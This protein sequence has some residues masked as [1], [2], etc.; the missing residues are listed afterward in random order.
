V[1]VPTANMGRVEVQS[2]ILR[3]DAP[4]TQTGGETRLAGGDV[5]ATAPFRIEGGG[6]TG[7]GTVDGSVTVTA[8]TVSPDAAS[9]S[10]KISGD[11]TQEASGTYTSELGPTASVVDR[12]EPLGTAA[13][14]GV[15][16]VSL[17]GGY[18][19]ARGDTFV[20]MTYGARTGQF[21]TVNVPA[22]SNAELRVLYN[23]LDVTLVV[24][25]KGQSGAD[26]E[27]QAPSPPPTKPL[28]ISSAPDNRA[29]GVAANAVVTAQ[30]PET[31]TTSTITA[32][33]FTLVRWTSSPDLSQ[34][35]TQGSKVAVTSTGTYDSSTRTATLRPSAPLVEGSTYTATIKSGSSGVKTLS[36]V[37]LDADKIWSFRTA[38]TADTTPPTA[39]M[40][41]SD[42]TVTGAA[43][44]TLQVNASDLG[45]GVAR[46]EFQVS[47]DGGATW[48]SVASTTTPDLRGTYSVATT[49]PLPPLPSGDPANPY[50]PYLTRAIATDLFGHQTTTAPV[51]LTVDPDSDA[52]GLPD[53]WETSTSGVNIDQVT[54]QE[55]ATVG[56][57]CV[58]VPL[59]ALGA[60]PNRRDVFV[61][62]DAMADSTHTPAFNTTALKNVVDAF[63][64]APAPPCSG[65]ICPPAGITLHIDQGPN[66]VFDWRCDGY[67]AI[68]TCLPIA[69]VTNTSGATIVVTTAVDLDSTVFPLNAQ[70]KI[71][72]AGVAGTASALARAD[73]NIGANG[74]WT[75]TV[76][77]VRTL[78]LTRGIATGSP[79]GTGT[80]SGTYTANSGVL[81]TE[82]AMWGT[83]SAARTVPEKQFLGTSYTDIYGVIRYRWEPPAG[84][85]VPTTITYVETE[86]RVPG[87]IRDKGRVP[88]FHYVVSGHQLTTTLNVTGIARSDGTGKGGDFVV[89]VGSKSQYA[90]NI[91]IQAG[92]LMHELGHNLGLEHGGG[93]T[94]NRKPNYLSVMNYNFQETGLLRRGADGMLT[95]GVMDYSRYGPSEIPEVDEAQVSEAMGLGAAEAT[96]GTRRDCNGSYT[97]V[98]YPATGT[99]YWDWDCD[100]A[101][102]GTTRYA[103]DVNG[104][105]VPAQRYGSYNDW[106]N[107]RFAGGNVGSAG[108][109]IQEPATE[110]E[111][112]VIGPA[113]AT[114]DAPIPPSRSLGATKTAI[115]VELHPND[116]INPGSNAP[117]QVVIFSHQGLD[118][119]TID[120]T[121]VRFG[122][123][124]AEAA[125]VTRDRMQERDTDG[126]GLLDLMVRFDAQEIRLTAGAT[127]AC[128]VGTLSDGTNIQGCASVRITVNR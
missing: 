21:T 72:V 79:A 73:G 123:P 47:S 34:D 8:G 49:Q 43:Q 116:A 64:A 82:A 67:V 1:S 29:Q 124:G 3:F 52:D 76:T 96:Y 62:I 106:A 61:Q 46:V 63:A 35:V 2:G 114:S 75:A 65:Q 10:L 53:R 58:N 111:S 4:Y 17:V 5:V 80:G 19:P 18:V 81:Y 54:G 20:I 16:N 122:P 121:T 51:S 95:S 86:K 50:K 93:D 78:S 99:R 109:V 55:C 125:R 128:L 22:L 84:T 92:T 104:D 27:G 100:A 69:G 108:V 117:L 85:T 105:G 57:T 126:D 48:Q 14:Q 44:P 83:R 77:G 90:I 28:A 91:K 74:L 71:A 36:G 56:G 94:I 66:S 11:Y 37:V 113:S 112:L 68:R 12:L 45:S 60:D 87:G 98:T 6:L 115:R 89:T 107:L 97:E 42:K 40:I 23:P 26:P 38:V 15:L 110:V 33:T 70:V 120:P 59:K 7:H 119:T 31:M 39:T 101:N 24:D 9:G 127:Q 13:L 118:A 32:S 88:I 103:R 41:T 102:D 30:F 25:N